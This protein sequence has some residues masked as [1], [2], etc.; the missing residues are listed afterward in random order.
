MNVERQPV[1][2]CVADQLC[3]KQRQTELDN[4]LKKTVLIFKE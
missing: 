1:Q 3:K 4:T 2:E